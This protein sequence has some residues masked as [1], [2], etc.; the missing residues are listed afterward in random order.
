MNQKQLDMILRIIKNSSQPELS[1]V[2]REAMARNKKDVLQEVHNQTTPLFEYLIPLIA[3]KRKNIPYPSTWPEEINSYLLRIHAKNG[4]KASKKR[5]LEA[6]DVERL[7]DE[8]LIPNLKAVIMGKMQSERYQ[9]K[10]YSSKIQTIVK[11]YLSELLDHP[12]ATLG[13]MGV[14]LKYEDTNTGVLIMLIDGVKI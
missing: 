1:I 7:L 13:K 6:E 2:L 9:R 10:P 3:L 4:S 8:G 11:D 12:H 14:S 5:W